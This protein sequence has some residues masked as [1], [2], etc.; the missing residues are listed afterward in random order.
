[1]NVR[2]ALALAYLLYCFWPAIAPA[3]TGQ[4]LTAAAVTGKIAAETLG[5]VLR[6]EISDLIVEFEATDIT[7]EL[8]ADLSRRRQQKMDAAALTLKRDLYRRLKERNLSA[9]APGDTQPVRDFSHLPMSL[10]RVRDQNVLMRLLAQPEVKAV[11]ENRRAQPMANDLDLIGQP[12]ASQLLGHTG[13]GTT[14]VVL[15]TGVDYT[16]SN[17]GNCPA[18][19][20]AVPPPTCKVAAAFDLTLAYGNYPYPPVLTVPPYYPAYDDGSKDN[21]G[22]GT[23]VAATLLNAAPNTRIVAIDV[24]NELPWSDFTGATTDSLLAGINWAIVNQAAYNVV[25]INMSL[26]G[27]PVYAA[28]CAANNP[29]LTAVQQAKDDHGILT[30]AASGNN[31]SANGLPWPAC[32]PGVLSVGSVYDS[33]ASGCVPGLKDTVVCGANVSNYLSLLTPA[34]ATSYAAPLGSAAAAVMAAAYP[35]E[36]PDDWVIR[37]T[38][39]GKT[40]A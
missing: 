17:F 25:A 40:R 32:T 11:S 3:Q 24:M 29:M 34:L 10:L 7:G 2:T 14:V 21:V 18:P 22:H 30:V 39:T 31:S 23:G 20:P 16:L 35:A 8:R 28:P 27:G 5:K 1:M 12:Q 36:S 37:M 13:A 4:D 6:G 15:D 33:N 26:A 9:L 38:T 19:L